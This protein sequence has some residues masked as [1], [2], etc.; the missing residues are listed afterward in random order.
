VEGG[1]LQAQRAQLVVTPSADR[2]LLLSPAD[3]VI[4]KRNASALV[5]GI[6]PGA[7]RRI[8]V[9]GEGVPGSG[10]VKFGEFDAGSWKAHAAG[11]EMSLR[12]PR[13]WR[14]DV[15]AERVRLVV[16]PANPQRALTIDR[17]ALIG[18]GNQ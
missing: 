18:I 4:R 15:I 12:W 2:V 5:M 7:V 10:W 8:E 9:W 13:E 14:D 6:D 16:I 1:S 17:L 3:Q 11:V